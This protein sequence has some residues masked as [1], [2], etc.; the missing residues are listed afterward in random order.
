MDQ[1]LRVFLY[2]DQFLEVRDAGT[3]KKAA[4]KGYLQ[5]LAGQLLRRPGKEFWDFHRRGLDTIE[6]KIPRLKFCFILL[7]ELANI[8]GNPKQTLGNVTKTFAERL[9][10]R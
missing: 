8:V 5:F 9:R 6:Y 7:N 10:G 1:F 2:A 4:E 3:L